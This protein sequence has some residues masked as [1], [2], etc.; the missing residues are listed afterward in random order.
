MGLISAIKEATSNPQSQLRVAMAKAPSK[1]ASVA[2][3]GTT[4]LGKAP[5]VVKS[6]ATSAAAKSVAGVAKSALVSLGKAFI[7]QPIKTTAKVGGAILAGSILTSSKKARETIVK[8]PGN[9][10]QFGTNIGDFI[11]NPNL[12]SLTKIGADNPGLSALAV[13]TG[14][15][16]IGKAT[17]SI[18]TAANTEALKD[19][20]EA[21][22]NNSAASN[23]DGELPSGGKSKDE[24]P[25]SNPGDITKN[26]SPSD[27]GE[28]PS[29]AKPLDKNPFP[30]E[31]PTPSTPKKPGKKKKQ[32]KR[33]AKVYKCH[34][35]RRVQHG[36]ATKCYN[37][38]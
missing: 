23:L 7:N 30:G 38:Y 3:G 12:D 26:P 15:L 36:S 33:K 16:L 29:G 9:L 24:K 32:A 19:N 8:A 13:L 1:S 10:A 14:G 6:V 28:S 11:D 31:S 37:F 22:K 4:I 35:L 2:F 5:S 20:T 18:V 17:S 27:I 25:V 21:A 34:S